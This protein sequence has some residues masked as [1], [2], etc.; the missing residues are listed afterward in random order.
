MKIGKNYLAFRK[1]YNSNK[2]D[3]KEEKIAMAAWIA[4]IEF[5]TQNY[6]IKENKDDE[7]KYFIG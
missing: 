5:I 3:E 1:W 6:E 7:H 2:G 4:A